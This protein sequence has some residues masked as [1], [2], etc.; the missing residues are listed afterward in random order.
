MFVDGNVDLVASDAH[1]TRRRRCW[2]AEAGELVR[3]RLGEDAWHA[4]ADEAPSRVIAQ[5]ASS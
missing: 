2:L 4:V 1:G 5:G 3:L